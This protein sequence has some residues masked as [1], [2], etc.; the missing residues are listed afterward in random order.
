MTTSTVESSLKN[1]KSDKLEDVPAM[2]A[3]VIDCAWCHTLIERVV[4]TEEGLKFLNKWGR[5]CDR[6]LEK[7]WRWLEEDGEETISVTE[8][9]FLGL[10]Q[11]SQDIAQAAH[12]LNQDVAR[13]GV[14][15]AGVVGQAVGKGL[16]HYGHN[17]V[18]CE[19]NT[20]VLASL[21]VEGYEA[22]TPEEFPAEDTDATMICVGTPTANG[23]IDLSH[24]EEACYTA[25]MTIRNSHRYHL[26]VLRCT[27]PPG[28]TEEFVMPRLEGWSGK[29][30][31][32]DFGV[33][34]HPE[35]LREVSALE[36]FIKPW[37]IV[38]AASDHQADRAFRQLY[39]PISDQTEASLVM[40][41]LRAAEMVK[42]AHNLFN[43]TKISFTNEIW[44]VCREIG[45]DGNTVMD[46]VSQSAEGMWNPRYGIR[47]GLPYG[48]SCLPKDTL[49][50]LHFAR[51]Q[52]IDTSLLQ[53]VIQVNDRMAREHPVATRNLN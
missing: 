49:A 34:Y 47:G 3:L 32:T 30:L 12:A 27:V 48:G 15:G 29:S 51:E 25:A 18:F 23:V 19:I 52:E 50:F 41:D 4:H 21:K 10:S 33:C 20:S 35:F 16:A 26:I 11:D 38:A 1:Q 8:S 2:G 31:G 7:T 6:C 28:T 22:V 43:A 40:T 42:Y 9:S 46:I 5:K 53:A 44:S 45:I 39:Q 36:D 17:V 14:I 24:L 13:I 37:I